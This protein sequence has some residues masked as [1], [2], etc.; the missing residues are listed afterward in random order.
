VRLFYG[1]CAGRPGH[2]ELRSF[3][4]LVG[5]GYIGVYA[6]RGFENPIPPKDFNGTLNL[7]VIAT[8]TESANG[9]TKSTTATLAVTVV[10]VNDAPVARNATYW[11]QKNGSVIIDFSYLLEDVDGD[12]L[13]LSMTNPA[14]GTLTRNN[15]GTYTYVPASGYIGLDAFSYTVFDGKLACE[16]LGSGLSLSY[17]DVILPAIMARPLRL[18]LAGALYHVTSREGV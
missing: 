8:A 15:N 10:P 16:P 11:V 17:F 6:K 3:D 5:P 18:E 9:D 13:S 7:G 14:H 12:M 2:R 4:P 1:I